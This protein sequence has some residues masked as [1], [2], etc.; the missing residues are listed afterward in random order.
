MIIEHPRIL[1]TKTGLKGSAPII[2]SA[3]RSTHGQE[4][5]K[6]IHLA[7]KKMGVRSEI[8]D[9]PDGQFLRT[10]DGPTIVTGNLADSRCIKMLY[11]RSLCATD[12]WYPGPAGYELR[13]LCNPFG[14]GHNVILIGYSDEKGAKDGCEV[15]LSQLGDPIP[16]LKELKITRL[17]LS[18]DEAE[19]YRTELLPDVPS[20]VANVMLGDWKGYLYYLT[21]ESELGQE[22]R[23]AWKAI[24]EAGYELNEQ[25][26]QAHLYSLMRLLPWRIVEDMDLFSEE[27]RLAITQFLYGWA[28]SKEGWHHVADCPRTQ[29]PNNPRQNHEMVPALALMYVAEYF[30]THFPGISGPEKWR[31]VAQ[32]TFEPYGSSWKPLCDGLCH[33]WWMSQ[34]VMLEYALYDPTHRYFEEGG[35]KQAAECAMAIVNNDG[36][37]PTAGDC[38]LKR[39]F[40][41][42]SLRVAAAYYGDGRFR[43]VHD[44]ATPDRQLAM[45]TTLPRAFDIGLEPC[46]P[47]EMVGVTVV[48]VDPLVYHVWKHETELAPDVV[49]TA[50]TAPIDQCFDK[51]AVRTGWTLADDYLL[52]DGLGGGSHSY[53]DAGGIIEYA[54]LGVSLIVQEDSFI[55]SAPEHHSTVTIVRNGETGVIPGF[56]IL[57]A[58]ETNS[59]GTVYFR[60]RLKDFAGTD[61]VREIHLFPEKCAVFVDTVTAN[62]AGDFAIEAHFRTPTQLALEGREAQGKRKSPCV[63]KIDVRL[64][65]LCD[66][67]KLSI[68]EEPIHLRYPDPKDQTRWKE[69]Y[70]TDEMRL[71]TFTA[72]ETATLEPG[73]SV[74]LIHLAQGCAPDETAIRLSEKRTEIF[75]SN[76]KTQESLTSFE[77]KKP[78]KKI[79]ETGNSE[80]TATFNS[81][82]DAENQI[83][84]LCLLDNGSIAVGTESGMLIFVKANGNKAWEKE[85]EGPVR[86][87][88]AANELLVA[89][90]GPASL[91]CFNEVG[92]NLWTTEIK[93]DLSPWPWWELTTPAA[94]QVAGGISNGEP[95]FAVGCGDLQLRCFDS[96]GKERWNSRH[97]GGVPG[98]IIVADIDGSGKHRIVEG[99]EILSCQS[100][101]RIFEPDGQIIANLPVEGWTS[102]LTALTFGEDQERH[103]IGCGANRGANLHLYELKDNKWERRWLK[104]PG[105]QVNDIQILATENRIIAATSQGFLLCYDL[106]GEPIWHRLFDQ[107]IQH[108]APMKECLLAIDNSGGLRKINLSGKIEDLASLPASCSCTATNSSNTYLTCDSKIWHV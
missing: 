68:T 29:R 46:L 8:I 16:H 104:R 10:A 77:I 100:A 71:T 56:A 42:P 39:Q 26:V 107:G 37:L 94:V 32:R 88:G 63:E 81:F 75:L 80:K 58:N 73:E 53:D 85:L 89:G 36:W 60:L 69:R 87:I 108:L 9:D 19:N 99:G 20:Q 43:F 7:L 25:I 24:I 41:G 86:D 44:L 70:R 31:T 35:A 61:W 74:R 84:A 91:T 40:P 62:T 48:P 50:P 55:Q 6:R 54:R 17:Q 102:I 45:L 67:S 27:E 5:A 1:K 21:G 33:G 101:C 23:K 49:S 4:V 92:E 12:L 95:F 52:I 93:R 64:E 14:S 83:T 65:S 30:E 51:L 106:K 98:R 96:S 97:Y 38:D 82:F 105:G 3:P 22:Y 2:I 15:F 13:T 59:D 57:E 76:G 28:E 72:R 66:A 103:F 11:F 79:V 47:E 78:K 34:P 18:P 90:Y